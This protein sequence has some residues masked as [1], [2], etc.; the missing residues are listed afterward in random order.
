MSV[1]ETNRLEELFNKLLNNG[2][3]QDFEKDWDKLNRLEQYLI[4]ILNKSGIEKMG[5][6]M[7][8][9]EV[10]LTACYN[11]SG[12]TESVLP[13]IEE[14]YITPTDYEQTFIAQT[15]L[16]GYNPVIVE[17]METFADGDEVAY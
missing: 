12:S 13:I 5:K 1:L 7:N 6:P 10:L 17:A 14:L 2:N 4:C 15:P 9:L 11:N 8:R 16:T 3:A